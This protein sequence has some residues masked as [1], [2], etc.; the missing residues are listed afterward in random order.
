MVERR[1]AVQSIIVESPKGGAEFGL[2]KKL[3]GKIF[4]FWIITVPV[5]FGVAAVIE[6]ICK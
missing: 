6:L 5:A 1:T 3:F 4:F 2:N